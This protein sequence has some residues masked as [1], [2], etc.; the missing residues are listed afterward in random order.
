MN[1]RYV[2]GLSWFHAWVFIVIF[3][4]WQ[5]YRCIHNCPPFSVLAET[6]NHSWRK[7]SFVVSLCKRTCRPSLCTISDESLL[8]PLLSLF[9]DE[10]TVGAKCSCSILS[11]WTSDHCKDLQG[12]A[13]NPLTTIKSP[14]T[15]NVFKQIHPNSGKKSRQELVVSEFFGVI[16]HPPSRHRRSRNHQLAFVHLEIW[17]DEAGKLCKKIAFLFQGKLHDEFAPNSSSDGC[18]SR[19]A[20]DASKARRHSQFGGLAIR[21][22]GRLRHQKSRWWPLAPAE[23]DDVTHC[24][25]WICQNIVWTCLNTERLLHKLM[26]RF[27]WLK[28]VE[29]QGTGADDCELNELNTCMMNRGQRNN[30]IPHCSTCDVKSRMPRVSDSYSIVAH[31]FMK[32]E[33]VCCCDLQVSLAMHYILKGLRSFRMSCT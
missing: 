5:W 10:V 29:V 15:I 9:H 20:C 17:T 4:S 6:D 31:Q 8:W 22:K 21:R 32:I 1:F 11:F 13:P 28:M 26:T 33:V 3:L 30:D 2:H 12:I 25:P 7:D 19:T 23:L 27:F 14:G 16:F 24:N 18:G